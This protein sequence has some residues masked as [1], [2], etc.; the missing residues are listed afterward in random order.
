MNGKSNL[1]DHI[2]FIYNELQ[3]KGGITV[4]EA[5]ER[6]YKFFSYLPTCKEVINN[7]RKNLKTF[8]TNK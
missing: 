4:K 3:N 6:M 8:N 1:T 2:N 7:M 5:S